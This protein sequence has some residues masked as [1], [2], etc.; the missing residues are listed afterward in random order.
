MALIL[1][2]MWEERAV[3]WYTAMQCVRVDMLYSYLDSL[4][5]IAVPDYLPTLQDILR[6]RVPTTGIIE[7]PFDLDSIIF[8]WAY[9]I[10]WLQ[11]S[12]CVFSHYALEVEGMRYLGKVHNIVN[13]GKIKSR[14]VWL[15]LCWINSVIEIGS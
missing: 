8:R 1:L 15:P 13:M 12:I 3:C 11:M 7:Y 4:D 2:D 14:I 5:R 10:V 6:A 9:A